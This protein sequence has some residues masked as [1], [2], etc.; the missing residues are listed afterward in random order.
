MKT[1]KIQSKK[2]NEIIMYFIDNV[3][4]N[5]HEFHNKVTLFNYFHSGN[6]NTSYTEKTKSGN[7]KHVSYYSI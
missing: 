4:V 2:T 7:Y 1:V 3:R 6:Y 5:V